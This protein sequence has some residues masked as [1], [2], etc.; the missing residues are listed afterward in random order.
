MSLELEYILVSCARGS[1]FG[2]VAIVVWI[3]KYSQIQQTKRLI[4]KYGATALF[5]VWHDN[6]MHAM[7]R[8][9]GV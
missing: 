7:I 4:I 3:S 6:R 1:I 8:Y 2:T 5:P 9:Y